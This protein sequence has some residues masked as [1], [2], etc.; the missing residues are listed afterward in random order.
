MSDAAAAAAAAGRSSQKKRM[1]LSQQDRYNNRDR[2]RVR[3]Y[4]IRT[5]YGYLVVTFIFSNM[6]YA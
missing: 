6:L 3:R 2:D 4:D 5:T 1:D